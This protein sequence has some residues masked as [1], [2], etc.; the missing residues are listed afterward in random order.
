MVVLMLLAGVI[1]FLR[2]TRFNMLPVNTD[3]LFTMWVIALAFSLAAFNR[4][5]SLIVRGILLLLSG[6][7]MVYRFGL[8]ITWLAGWLP[9]MIALG[10]LTFMR[11]KKLV[12]L[13]AVCLLVVFVVELDFFSNVFWQNAS[14]AVIRACAPGRRTGRSP[15]S[16][17]SSAP[18]QQVMLLTTC[19]TSPTERWRHTATTSTSW[20]K[21]ALL[22]L[23]CLCGSSHL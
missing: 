18:A 12:L 7:W 3:G 20:L 11:S 15:E 10:V 13:L 5:L 4:R 22:A 23:V 9:P 2:D 1:G 8:N 6:I 16:T 17:C 19:L 21:P 14:R